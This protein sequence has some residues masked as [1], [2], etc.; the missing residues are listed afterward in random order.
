MTSNAATPFPVGLTTLHWG[1]ADAHPRALLLHGLTSAGGTWWQV[2]SALAAGGW[3]VTAPDLRG[4]GGSPR[5]LRYRLADYAAD[6]LA[7]D[8]PARSTVTASTST[9]AAGRPW[10]LVVG[11]SLGGAVATVAA[12]AHQDWT[13]ALLL[14][15]PVLSMP[16]DQH[17]A[18][19]ADLLGDLDHLDADD[20]LRANP[21]WHTEDAVQ[22][23]TAA[24]VVSPFVVE[25]TVR[26]NVGW[27]LE[28]V[29][30]RIRSHVRVLGADPQLGASF[31][32]AEG[33]R[34]SAA[35]PDSFSFAVV[36]GAGHSIHRDDPD[37]VVAEARA[38]IAP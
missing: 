32:A 26:D 27:N 15:D 23:V 19:I 13:R 9:S 10:D 1:E 34:L 24:R 16:D 38:L 29:A 30:A 21:R 11:H 17:D 33:D 25:R 14:L 12:Q 8:P 7:L 3:S 4:H 5:T 28:P 37:R 31:T 20:L 36:E 18:V 35:S 2:A 22:K 6:V